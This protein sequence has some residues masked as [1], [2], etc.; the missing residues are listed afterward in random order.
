MWNPSSCN[1]PPAASVLTPWLHT[2]S[3]RRL[4][5]GRQPLEYW[6]TASLALFCTPSLHA[7]RPA[8]PH[9][10]FSVNTITLSSGSELNTPRLFQQ[11]SERPAPFLWMLL[12]VWLHFVN[13]SSVRNLCVKTL[14]SQKTWH[15]PWVWFPP[16]Y[17]VLI[18]RNCYSQQLAY[19]VIF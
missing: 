10:S 12:P 9:W 3:L 17:S 16:L 1:L 7:L 8:S 15:Y 13:S 19:L 5:C 18:L 6:K 11:Q 14:W 4:F 2:Q